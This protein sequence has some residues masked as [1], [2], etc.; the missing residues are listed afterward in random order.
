MTRWCTR[1]SKSWK[2]AADEGLSMVHTETGRPEV[3]KFVNTIQSKVSA[4][5]GKIDYTY[6][7]RAY[8]VRAI[9][10]LIA[11]NDGKYTVGIRA[12]IPAGRIGDFEVVISPDKK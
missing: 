12:E 5:E 1:C 3:V 2:T 11:E 6:R 4:Q 9:N 10:G 8:G 7:E